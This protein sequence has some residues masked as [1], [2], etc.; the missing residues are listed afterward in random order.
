L[1]WLLIA[2]YWEGFQQFTRFS[3]TDLSARPPFLMGVSLMHHFHP[4]ASPVKDIGPS[5]NNAILTIDQRLIKV[6]TIALVP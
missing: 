3:L 5:R 6:E 4:K 2:P 1:A